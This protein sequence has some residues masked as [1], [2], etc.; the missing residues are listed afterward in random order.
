VGRRDAG[1]ASAVANTAQQIGASMGTAL[2]NTVAAAAT[3][4]LATHRLGDSGHEAALVHG[5]ATAA[6]WAAGILLVAAMAV[7]W[8]SNA[9]PPTA[10]TTMV[11]T[12][13]GDASSKK[14]LPTT[15]RR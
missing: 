3:H 5:Y 11:P 4:H 13:D 15:M 10:P 2:L 8:L 1:V 6:G 9:D 12:G 7:G 14:P